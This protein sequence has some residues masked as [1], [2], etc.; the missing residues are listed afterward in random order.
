MSYQLAIFDRGHESWRLHKE[1]L[2]I[3]D[4][5]TI[6]EA[7]TEAIKVSEMNDKCT[8]LVITLHT[9]FRTDTTYPVPEPVRNTDRVPIKVHRR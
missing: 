6:E 2:D 5:A 1:H 7:E 9:G 3:L 8:V 4:F